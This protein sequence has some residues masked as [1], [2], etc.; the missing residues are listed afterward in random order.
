MVA[1]CYWT[2]GLGGG[3]Q[4]A[5]SLLTQDDLVDGR[6]VGLGT[7]SEAAEQVP[8]PATPSGGTAL[9]TLLLSSSAEGVLSI[10]LKSLVEADNEDVNKALAL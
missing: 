3:L 8:E 4:S 1:R 2:G 10:V 5:L 6:E 7:V 9:P